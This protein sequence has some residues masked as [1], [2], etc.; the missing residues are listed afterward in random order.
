MLST[1]MSFAG[2]IRC[3]VGVRWRP[4]GGASR[5]SVM[6][7]VGPRLLFNVGPLMVTRL[8]WLLLSL[9]QSRSRSRAPG[10]RKQ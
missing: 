7:T 1:E 5:V 4:R 2:G 8:L 9:S 3:V 6:R 10:N